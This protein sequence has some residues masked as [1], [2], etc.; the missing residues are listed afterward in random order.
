MIRILQIFYSLYLAVL[1]VLVLILLMPIYLGS[2]LL[3]LAKQLPYIFRANYELMRLWCY[4]TGIR[5][6]V[7]GAAYRQAGQNYVCVANH[8]NMLDMVT[9]TQ[10]FSLPVKPLA[11]QEFARIP[12]LGSIFKRFAVLVVRGSAESRQRSA[13]LLI[14]A[15]HAGDSIMIYPEGTRN[16]TAAPLQ[17][18]KDGAFRAA[19]AAQTPILP[20]VQ[21]NMRSVQAPGHF[22]FRPGAV[23]VRFLPPLATAGLSDADVPALR[24]QV[25]A[26]I[27]AELRRDDA[28]FRQR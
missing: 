9:F 3:P 23:I 7:E 6:R 24:N 22:L 25:H 17:A 10:A 18:F 2:A 11:K 16:R 13:R 1:F 14:E 19:V 20:L 8:C 28:A 5:V 21:I 4:L 27:E 15:L 12:L 26:M